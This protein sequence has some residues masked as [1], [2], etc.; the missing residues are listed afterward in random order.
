LALLAIS[1]H[2]NGFAIAMV[3]FG[4]AMLPLGY[5]IYRSR[6]LPKPIGVLLMIAALGYMF[7]STAGFLAPPLADALFPWTL[8]PGFVAEVALCLWLLLKGVDLNK[9]PTREA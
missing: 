6:Y 2:A 3:F 9:W 1:L 8:L 7:N 4:A 5:L